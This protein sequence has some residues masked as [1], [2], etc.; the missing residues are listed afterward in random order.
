MLAVIVLDITNDNV[1]TLWCKIYRHWNVKDRPSLLY[2]F[3]QATQSH[4]VAGFHY[5]S[6]SVG[7]RD[8]A[9]KIYKGLNVREYW[10]NQRAELSPRG[11]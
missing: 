5:C 10:L 11:P 8:H 1:V 3:T 4:L 9:A 6:T 2:E 7:K